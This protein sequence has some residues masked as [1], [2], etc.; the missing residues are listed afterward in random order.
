MANNKPS[1]GRRRI[2]K[3]DAEASKARERVTTIIDAIPPEDLVASIKRAPSLRGMILGYIAELMFEKYVPRTYPVILSDD[4]AHHDDHDRTANKSDR[5]ITFR[6]RRYGVQLKSIQTNS[7]GREIATG[8]LIADV[9]NDASDRRAVLLS[10]GSRLETTCY[11]RDEYDVLAVPL[12]PLTGEW[13]FAYKRNKDCRTCTSRKYSEFQ[14][15][16]LLATTERLCWP[17]GDDWTTNLLDLLDD[18]IGSPIGVPDVI[19][20]PSGKVRVIE[21]SAVILPLKDEEV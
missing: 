21:S 9:Q 3:G 1:I 16:H 2:D 4:I 18:Q 5:T 7:I 13:N 12:F 17:L 10:D 19:T 20:E 14:A 11:V 8:K 6:G 15:T